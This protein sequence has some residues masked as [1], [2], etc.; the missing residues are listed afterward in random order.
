MERARRELSIDMAVREPTWKTNKQ[1]IPF[2]LH[3]KI[4]SGVPKTGIIFI[5][6]E[7]D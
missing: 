4:G 6:V 5:S 3:L 7:L 2:Y 1:D